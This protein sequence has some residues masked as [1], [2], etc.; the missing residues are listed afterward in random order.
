MLPGLI[1]RFGISA[2]LRGN[3]G[4]AP[5]LSEGSGAGGGLEKGAPE[6]RVVSLK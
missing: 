5:G 2:C 4:N 6:K 3:L 1:P